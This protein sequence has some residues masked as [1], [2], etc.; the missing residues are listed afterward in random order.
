VDDNYTPYRLLGQHGEDTNYGMGYFRGRRRPT[1]S[2]VCFFLCPLPR[3]VRMKSKTAI[4]ASEPV[5]EAIRTRYFR[6]QVVVRHYLT[7]SNAF[8]HAKWKSAGS[9]PI[10]KTLCLIQMPKYIWVVEMGTTENFIRSRTQVQMVLNANTEAPETMPLNRRP[11][12]I[13]SLQ[14]GQNLIGDV[15]EIYAPRKT[16]AT[17]PF[18]HHITHPTEEPHEKEHS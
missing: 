13:V 15:D 5:L 1:T 17:D 11:Q 2:D 14:V 3:Q 8:K 18:K 9:E 16:L 7:S 10:N 6:S 12:D 4:D